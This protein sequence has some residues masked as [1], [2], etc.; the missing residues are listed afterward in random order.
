MSSDVEANKT[1]WRAFLDYWYLFFNPCDN[2][3]KGRSLSEGTVWCTFM[4][5]QLSRHG[6]YVQATTA[7]SWKWLKKMEIGA[8]PV[9]MVTWLSL[10]FWWCQWILGHD[11]QERCQKAS[12]FQLTRLTFLPNHC[13]QNPHF[14]WT[15][16]WFVDTCRL[17]DSL[18]WEIENRRMGDSL[19]HALV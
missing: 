14:C 11:Q 16:H 18:S 4:G 13:M 17:G 10:K 8:A 7:P 6:G 15:D 19:L 9:L 1:Q 5:Y 2:R 12:Q 3:N